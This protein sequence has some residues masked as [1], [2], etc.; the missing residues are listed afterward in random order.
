MPIMLVRSIIDI[1]QLPR[2]TCLSL[3]GVD[4]S[5]FIR[6]DVDSVPFFAE[7]RSLTL[8]SCNGSAAFLATMATLFQGLSSAT[9]C[10]TSRR[11]VLEQFLF[12]QESFSTSLRD[13]LIVFLRSFSG[14]KTLSL[15]FENTSVLDHISNLIGNHGATLAQLVLETR[16]SPRK[17]SHINTSRPFGYGGYNDRLWE[18]S[19]MAMCTSCPNLTELGIGF[20]WKDE[21]LRSHNCPITSLE[22]LKAIHIRNFPELD[23]QQ[24]GNHT[25]KQYARKLVDW[26]YTDTGSR[27]PPPLETLSIGPTLYETK[28]PGSNPSR[29]VVPEWLRTHHFVVDWAK[30][31]FGK[32]TAMISPVSERYV[33]E[34]RNEDELGGIF[35]Q[36]WLK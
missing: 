28:H 29:N 11:P 16:I 23:V 3:V 24:V 12:R 21:T 27:H 17:L 34:L 5:L 15:L 32:W 10:T 4:V 7:L 35:Q 20:S 25:T 18:E 6:E 8:E 31:R 2:L 26:M 22:K 13:V 9:A 30:T 14:L 36:V 33:Q 19:T 1:S